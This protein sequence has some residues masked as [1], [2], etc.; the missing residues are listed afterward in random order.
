MTIAQFLSIHA[1]ENLN[2]QN[3]IPMLEEIIFNDE[4][5]YEYD[6]CTELDF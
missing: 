2:S 6:V 4:N 3:E 1:S 5:D